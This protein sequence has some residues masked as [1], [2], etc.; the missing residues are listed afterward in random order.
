MRL[1][2]QLRSPSAAR[3]VATQKCIPEGGLRGTWLG[4]EGMHICIKERDME[5]WIPSG[6][7]GR[8]PEG[9]INLGNR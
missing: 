4:E 8:L 9:G 5:D 2:L 6:R 7:P 3:Q 1:S